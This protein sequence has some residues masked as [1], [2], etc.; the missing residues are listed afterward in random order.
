MGPW[1]DLYSLGMTMRMCITGKP[2]PTAR[3]RLD[4]EKLVPVSKTHSRKYSREILESID[5]AIELE[6]HRRPQDANA[7]YQLMTSATKQKSKGGFMHW[8]S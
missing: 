5:W 4:G 1:S 8:W 7:L 6:Q 2:P 3:Q